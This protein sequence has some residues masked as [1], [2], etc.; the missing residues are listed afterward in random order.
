MSEQPAFDRLWDFNDPA[1]SEQRF[2]DLLDTGDPD[3]RARILSQVARAQGLQR[4]F[5]EALAT[6]DAAEALLAGAVAPIARTRIALERGRTLNSS[7][8]GDRGRAHFV[9]ALDLA[10]GAGDDLLAIDAV[11]MLAIIEPPEK[12]IE[13]NLRAMEMA[14]ASKNE[15][16]KNWLGAL[17]NNIGW[18]Y[19]DGGNF[20]KALEIFEK[21]LAWRAARNQ[22]VET[23][24]AK[25]AVARALRSLG[26]VEEAFARQTELL[27]EHERAQSTDGYVNEELGECLLA[28][29][30]AAEAAPQ[31]RRAWELLSK[32]DWLAANEAARLERLKTL[33]G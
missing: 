27:A 11:H 21:A 7:K 18:A 19:H 13:W 23:R 10:R 26:R 20:E 14:E 4:K 31:F 24:I 30:R 9:A 32:D 15:R 12:A 25:W 3:A 29:G 28:L 33:G 1:A 6:L 16:A 8:Q 5:A 22:P 17:Y 2:R